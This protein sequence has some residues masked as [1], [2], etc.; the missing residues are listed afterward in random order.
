MILLTGVARAYFS[1]R[2]DVTTH[3]EQSSRASITTEIVYSSA[4]AAF[5]L[6]VLLIMRPH[7]ITLVAMELIQL[8]L[9]GNIVRLC[10]MSTDSQVILYLWMGQASFFYQVHMHGCTV[11]LIYNVHNVP[12]G[13]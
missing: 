3:N 5:S 13:R 9:L 8:W 12:P 4:F 1:R 2:T 7:N 6:V 10:D 11:G